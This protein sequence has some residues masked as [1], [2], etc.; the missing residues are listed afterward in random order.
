MFNQY[1]KH[2]NLFANIESKIHFYLYHGES[3]YNINLVDETKELK[4]LLDSKK[5]ACIEFYNMLL[6]VNVMLKV[7]E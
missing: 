6:K 7:L 3:I 1:K 5:V 4:E 2:W